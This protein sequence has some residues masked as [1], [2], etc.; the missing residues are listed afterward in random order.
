MQKTILVTGSTDGIGLVAAEKLVASGHRVL[1]HGR[2][3]HK[4][5]AARERLEAL[6]GEGSVDGFLADLSRLAEV[7]AFAD[8]IVEQCPS[9]DVLV[10]NAGVLRTSNTRT[11]D[12]LDVRFA[13]NTIAP[14]LLTK[15]LLPLLGAEGR[16]INVSSAAQAP[17][18]L[19]ALAGQGAL[20]DMEAYAQSKL[21]ITA[22]S[23]SLARALGEHGP[24]IV[25]VNPG[26]ML[27]SKMVEEAFGVAGRD[28]DIGGEILVRAALSDPFA[29]ASGR[30]F[31]N[32]AGA[33]GQPHADVV[34]E[35]KAGAI[36]A[37]M[38]TLL[39]DG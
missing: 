10:N 12:G 15:R 1:L 36:V 21:A 37:A 17:V 5:Q 23:R 14:Y 9:L 16:V 32:D 34:D 18:Q 11:D 6:P 25:S 38:D 19:A 24:V 35:V 20:P 30:Y 31:D 28:I 4:L 7:R 8:R 29:T 22:W 39:A 26:S 13:V 2:S 3:A 33:F 27:G